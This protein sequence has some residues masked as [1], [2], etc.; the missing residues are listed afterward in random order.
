MSIVIT[1]RLQVVLLEH[2]IPTQFGSS[3]K[4][5]CPDGS[6]SLRTLLH[7]R[8]EHDLKS[9]VVFVDLI[10][11]FDSIHHS[12]LFILLKKT[13]IPDRVIKVVKKLYN[14]FKIEIKVGDISKLIDYRTGVK[15]GD[16]LASILFN[17]V[18]QF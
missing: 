2:G 10:K 4:T 13:G 18:M 11:A 3:P 15:Q 12:L 14:D 8:K 5:G 7:M 17:I 9:W 6:F 1:T 16:N